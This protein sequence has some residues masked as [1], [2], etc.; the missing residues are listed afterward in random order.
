LGVYIG[1]K[2]GRLLKRKVELAGGLILILIGIKILI[3]HR[4]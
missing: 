1:I 3:E 2:V 4:P